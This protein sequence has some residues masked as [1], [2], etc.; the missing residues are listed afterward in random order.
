MR[1]ITGRYM[2]R[3][4]QHAADADIFHG[5]NHGLCAVPPAAVREPASG[6]GSR[7]VECARRSRARAQRLD[8][9][10]GPLPDIP[11]M[12]DPIELLLP[13]L[14]YVVLLLVLLTI[15]VGLLP[16]S[17]RLRRTRRWLGLLAAW[18]WLFSSP[19]VANL[20]VT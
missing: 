13:R 8:C 14:I 18:C 19:G 6:V 3:K 1:N 15:G 16:R 4:C 10:D 20:V 11:A 2:R 17:H 9:D 5:R 7:V 12:F